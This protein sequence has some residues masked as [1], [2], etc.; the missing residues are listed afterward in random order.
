MSRNKDVRCDDT[1]VV[2]SVTE[3]SEWDL[4]KQF[5]SIE[6]D[7]SIV[8]KQLL[9]WGELLRAGKKLRVDLSFNYLE[10]GPQVSQQLLEKRRQKKFLID[11]PANAR[12][13]STHSSTLK[14]KTI[15]VILSYGVMC[16]VSC[17]VQDHRAN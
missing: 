11:H 16:T 6:V 8:E 12:R 10:S 15:P 1:K 9:A 17:V 3:R 14:K 2:I 4:I 13:N 5:D 7:W